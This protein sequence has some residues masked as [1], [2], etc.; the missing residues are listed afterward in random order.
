VPKLNFFGGKSLGLA[1]K[2]QAKVL[3]SALFTARAMPYGVKEMA[4]VDYHGL[5]TEVAVGD[6]MIYVNDRAPELQLAERLYTT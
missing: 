4:V 1:N 3:E 2:R 6:G 5:E